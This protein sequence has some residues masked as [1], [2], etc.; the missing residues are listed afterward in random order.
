MFPKAIVSVDVIPVEVKHD[1]KS[2][3][4][5]DGV[6]SGARSIVVEVDVSA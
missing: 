2:D 5:N 3:E 6:K 4:V 1:V